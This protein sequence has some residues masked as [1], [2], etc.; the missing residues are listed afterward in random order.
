MQTCTW[1]EYDLS[2][3]MLGT[4]Q[5]GMAYG[6]ANTAGRPDFRQAVRLIAAAADGGVNCFDTAAAYGDSEVILGRTR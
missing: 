4:A 5:L 1:N 2:R 6:V 3:L